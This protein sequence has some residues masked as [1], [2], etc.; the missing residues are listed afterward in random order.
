MQVSLRC[1][2]WDVFRI[3]T[4]NKKGLDL[5]DRV[6]KEWV[7]G[8]E[9]ENEWQSK[10][11]KTCKKDTFG[12][13]SGMSTGQ[14][15]HSKTKFERKRQKSYMQRMG[16]WDAVDACAMEPTPEQIAKKIQRDLKQ[17]KLDAKKYERSHRGGFAKTKEG[18]QTLKEIKAERDK[19]KEAFRLMIR[20]ADRNSKWG[21]GTSYLGKT[22]VSLPLRLQAQLRKLDLITEGRTND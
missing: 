21:K 2:V 18:T 16:S 4:S 13:I 7:K 10:F 1:K 3:M 15:P 19:Y 12:I 22:R 5:L 14:Q 9:K 17:A 20:W 11:D 8:K 6:N